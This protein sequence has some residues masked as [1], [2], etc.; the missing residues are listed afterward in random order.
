MRLNGPVLVTGA[1]GNVGGA[2]A[3]SLQA[4]GIAPRVAG[5]DVARLRA[6]FPGVPAAHLDFGEPGTF[7]A[8]L[9]GAAGL[10]LIRPPRIARVGPT[11]NALVDHAVR[12]RVAHVVFASVAGADRNPVVPHH[13][14]ERHLRASGLPNTILR[15]G[16]FAQNL[17]D[18]YGRDIRD[19]GRIYLPAAAGRV[20]FVDT[21]DIGD[22][23]AAVFADPTAH[24]GAAHTL[25]GPQALDFTQVAALL[26][27]VLGRPVRY[28]PASVAGYL[29]HLRRRRV[30]VTQAL[31]QT[32]LHAGLR[33]GQAER[34]DPALPLLLGRPARTLRE[35][36]TEHRD[37]WRWT[38]ASEPPKMSE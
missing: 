1:T 35:Y 4:A 34:V 22:A 36:V 24:R 13:R 2:V 21:R 37:V 7:D 30:P 32:V 20:A 6:R 27:E 10:F 9:A 17:A 12:H 5:T 23:A 38:P 3:R 14:I 29:R 15:P 8:A 33:R 28:Q 31:V 25:T 26:T 19:D 11:L 18:A 16:F